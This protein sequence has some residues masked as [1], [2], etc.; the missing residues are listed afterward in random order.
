[1]TEQTLMLTLEW[2]KFSD[3]VEED[4]YVDKNVLKNFISLIY[5]T[6]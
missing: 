2:R 6:A 4:G 5:L 3:Y 1:M